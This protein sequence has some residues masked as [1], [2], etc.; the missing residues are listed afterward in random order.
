SVLTIY[1]LSGRGIERLT[2]SGQSTR[3]QLDHLP[4]GS[5]FVRVTNESLDE[6][7]RVILTR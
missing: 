3:I 2:F 1:D 5:Y 6:K 7:I 4:L